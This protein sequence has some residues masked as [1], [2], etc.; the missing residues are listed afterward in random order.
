MEEEKKI[1]MRDLKTKKPF[2]RITPPKIQGYEGIY[3]DNDEPRYD[4]GVNW[5]TTVTQAD[6]LREYYPTGHRINDQ[7]YYPDIWRVVDE[8]VY[9]SDG[10]QAT[11]EYGNAATT[12]KYYCE[13][14]PR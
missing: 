7:N 12:T 3:C 2:R 5:F 6:F 13:M 9:E 8:P 1:R 4:P 14:V 11:D 10:T